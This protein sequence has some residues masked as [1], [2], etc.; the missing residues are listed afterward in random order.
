[1][2]FM[3][4][5]CLTVISLPWAC[6]NSISS[7]GKTSI[8]AQTPIKK[9]LVQAVE[10]SADVW[11][12]TTVEECMKHVD[13]G[14]PF[15]FETSFNPFYLRANLDG[16]DLIDYALL[17]VGQDS[18]KRGVVICKDST[19]PFVFGSLAKRKTS[20]SSFEDDNFIT[21]EWE[22][23]TKEFTRIESDS[24]GRKIAPGAKGESVSFVF[25]G[26]N[27][28]NIYWDGKTFRIGE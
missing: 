25:E 8:P 24:T 23:S 1:M 26:G 16:N 2:K 19:Q 12:P 9:A 6:Q 11:I 27:G 18:K 20:L 15:K 13:V 4:L 21:P 7:S 17:I 22:I 5:L 3:I 14:E 28:V 10:T